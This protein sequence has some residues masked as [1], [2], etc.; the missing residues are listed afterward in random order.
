MPPDICILRVLLLE[1]ALRHNKEEIRQKKII[2]EFADSS[3]NAHFT[4][5]ED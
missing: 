3:P 5:M 1:S 4:L 2:S